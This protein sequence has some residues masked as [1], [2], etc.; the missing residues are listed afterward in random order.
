MSKKPKPAVIVNYLPT[1]KTVKDD[2]IA[3]VNQTME[4]KMAL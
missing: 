2:G 1:L 4:Y 3:T